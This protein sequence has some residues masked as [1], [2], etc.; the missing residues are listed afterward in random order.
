[1]SGAAALLSGQSSSGAA[2]ALLRRT[3]FPSIPPDLAAEA[4][5]TSDLQALT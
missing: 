4:F 3:A 5:L 1:M 2:V